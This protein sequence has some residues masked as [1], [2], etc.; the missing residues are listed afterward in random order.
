MDFVTLFARLVGA[1]YAAC[2]FGRRAKGA[3][4]A[5]PGA[6]AGLGRHSAPPEGSPHVLSTLRL[7]SP[8]T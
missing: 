3:R 7:F 6:E 4:G 8:G 1:K 2:R 5:V